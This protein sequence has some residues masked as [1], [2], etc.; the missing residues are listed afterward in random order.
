MGIRLACSLPSLCHT[1]LR[2]LSSGLSWRSLAVHPGRQC[3][4][5]KRKAMQGNAKHIDMS[6]HGIPAYKDAQP[7]QSPSA[8]PLN[9]R[10]CCTPLFHQT[11]CYAKGNA[12]K[13][14]MSRPQPQATKQRLYDST[15][16][17]HRGLSADSGWGRSMVHILLARL[18]CFRPWEQHF[19]DARWHDKIGLA[20][21]TIC[22]LYC[23]AAC[24][25]A[26]PGGP[27]PQRGLASPQS[28]R[29]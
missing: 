14:A 11:S 9:A 24:S 15:V 1:M 10:L 12:E 21:T 8:Q 13:E 17:G 22:T 3:Q 6:N 4:A 7:S 18:R 19:A 23:E 27:A 25:S 2:S 29:R 28:A 5:A 26:H 16:L 20:K